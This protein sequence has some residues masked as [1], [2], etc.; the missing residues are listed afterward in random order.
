[1]A[2]QVV[3][4]PQKG[5]DEDEQQHTKLLL[6]NVESDGELAVDRYI[7]CGLGLWQIYS[8]VSRNLVS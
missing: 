8:P 1:M 7:Y 5:R 4:R 2:L 3:M 6:K